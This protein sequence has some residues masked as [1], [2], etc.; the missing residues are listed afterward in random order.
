VKH[1]T[2]SSGLSVSATGTGVVA[3]AGS[4]A[5]R[6]LAD[7]VGLT[8][9]LSRAL[10]RRSFVPVPD[11][12]QVLVDIAVLLADGGEAIADIDVLR[13]QGLVL[14]P[15]A[16]APT[17]WRA[18]DELTPAALKRVDRARARTRAHVWSQLSAVPAS[19]VSLSRFLCKGAGRG[20]QV[21]LDSGLPRVWL[22]P[23]L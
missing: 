18:L 19:R 12:G 16:S 17:V 11:R 21:G 6:L 8:A 23:D 22:T 20:S 5:V 3:H 7:M 15:V 4:V 1:T 13:H 14:G 2:W 9:C 10:S